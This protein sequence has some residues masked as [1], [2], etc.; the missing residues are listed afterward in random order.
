MDVSELFPASYLSSILKIMIHSALSVAILLL[1]LWNIIFFHEVKKCN[2]IKRKQK[3]TWAWKGAVE[4]TDAKTK[5]TKWQI[6]PVYQKTVSREMSRKLG[7][8]MYKLDTWQWSQ[9][10]TLHKL[11]TDQQEKDISI[12][13]KE[14]KKESRQR[15]WVGMYF[16][17]EKVESA[18]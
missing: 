13:K 15:I 2:K 7:K 6:T 9:A 17:E 4:E 5:Q 1:F 11:K 10:P 14:R 3:T 18:K 16:W 8:R 12:V